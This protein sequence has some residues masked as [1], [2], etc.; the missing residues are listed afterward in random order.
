MA[1][2]MK[3]LKANSSI[4]TE[5][6]ESSDVKPAEAPTSNAELTGNTSG[7]SENASETTEQTTTK[8]G[9]KALVEYIGHGVWRDSNGDVWSK[10]ANEHASILTSRSYPVEEYENRQDFKFMEGY[11]EIKVTIV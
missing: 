6:K 5:L 9:K 10:T 2:D 1:I 11:G 8:S 3:N 4:N 7:N